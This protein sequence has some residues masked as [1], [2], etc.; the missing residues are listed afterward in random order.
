MQIHGVLLIFERLRH[1]LPKVT[2]VQAFRR[3]LGLLGFEPQGASGPKAR[4]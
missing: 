2:V 3:V 4:V 1:F